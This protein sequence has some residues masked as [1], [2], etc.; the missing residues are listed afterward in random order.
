MHS[1]RTK[2]TLLTVCAVVIALSIATLI[3]VVSI[4]NLGERDAHQMLDL[5]C[6]TGAMNL[7]SYFE[8]VEHSVQTVSTLVQDSLEDMPSDQ[9]GS[10]VER[11]RNLFGRVANNT[12]GVLTYYFRIDPEVSETVKGF[13]YVNLDGDGFREYELTDITQYD[14]N[15]TSALVWFTVPK[16]TGKGVW[17]PPYITDNLDVRV[18]SYNVPVYWKERFVGVIGIEI[19]YRTLSLEVE[20]IRPFD[21]GYAVI[22]D[23]NH[24]VIYHP[25]IDSTVLFGQEIVPPPEDL[26]VDSTPIH[27]TYDGTRKVAVW[28]QLSNGMRLYVI[29]PVSK[30]S[31][32]WQEM[33]RNILIASLI[34]LVLVSVVVMRYSSHITKPLRDLTEAARQV[35]KGNYEVALDYDKDDELGILTRTFSQ[36]ASHTKEHIAS[37]NQQVY[38]DALTSVRNKGGYSVYIQ[39]L[40]DQMDNPDEPLSFAFGVFDCDNLKQIND[41]YGHDKGDEYL[42]TASRLICR[43]FSHSPVFRIGGDEFAVILQNDDYRNREELLSLFRK[44]REEICGSAQN[45]WEKVGITMGL[46]VYDQQTD[47]SVIDVAR[48]ADQLMYENKRLRKEGQAMPSDEE[49]ARGVD[50]SEYVVNHIDQAVEQKWLKVYYHPVIRSLTGALCSVESLVRWDDPTVGFLNPA[51]FIGP[52]EKSRQIDKVDRFVV[53][54]VC[55]DI[56]DRIQAGKPVVPV[57]INCSRLDFTLCNMIE[58]VEQA[59]SRHG[60]PRD[61]IHI[62]VTESMIASDETLMRC[63]IEDFE[64]TGYE[65]WMDDFG[66]GYSSLTFLKDYHF[67]LLKMDMNFLSS[68]TDKSKKILRSIVLM[69]KELG[70]KTLA[71]GVETKEELDFLKEIGCGKIQG[72]YYGRP[73][74]VEEMFRHLDQIG[75]R[76]ETAEDGLFYEKA[77][78][79][80]KPTD[81]PLEIIEDDGVNFRTL[82]MNKAYKEQIFTDYPDLEEADRR[83]YHTPSPLLKKYREFADKLEESGKEETFYYTGAGSY[84]RFRAQVVAEHEGRYL[85]KGSIVNI[86]LNEDKVKA[87]GMDAKLRELNQ[88]FEAVHLLDLQNDRFTPLIGKFKFDGDYG[89][90]DTG[91]RDRLRII[92]EKRIRCDEKES[93]TSFAACDTLRERIGNSRLGYISRVFHVMQADGG[94]KPE[95]IILMPIPG[96]GGNEF[97][98]C[99]R[100]YYEQDRDTELRE[101]QEA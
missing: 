41:T 69:A 51:Q 45:P 18:I 54:Q 19:D 37:L 38:V 39:K 60:I 35:D 74:P 14:T 65:V 20:N 86:S 50:I 40:Q 9:L 77:C 85:M 7:D 21:E 23:E 11:A 88:L 92:S 83:I 81:A 47:T 2:F 98:F 87:D 93:F 28:K 101:I 64:K 91:L 75:I 15:D 82:Y 5:M 12:N 76:P 36:L 61:F 58:V 8:S 16:A 43:V 4:R 1:I 79:H 26:L 89:P 25:Q 32:G 70:I 97:L 96:S 22:I 66:S 84:L 100:Y 71:E 63:V 3:G 72:Y 24:D 59:V 30:I 42:K 52:L 13:W 62:E 99:T 10:Q 67:D 34:V 78:I 31:A 57:S 90:E 44:S 48:R 49:I 73:M 95:E 56:H 46:A 29:A 33:I 17:L 94:Y 68:F 55:L 80:V 27:Y 53:E 6:T